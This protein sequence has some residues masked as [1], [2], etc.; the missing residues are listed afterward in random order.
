MIWII[1]ALTIPVVVWSAQVSD[2][3]GYSAPSFAGSAYIP[4]LFGAIVLV[5]GGRVFLNG[6]RVKLASRQPGM[7]TLIS[8]AIAVAFVASAA[9][10]L[11]LFSVDVWWELTTLITVMS[12]GHWPEMRAIRQARGQLSALAELLL[13][14]GAL[15]M[16]LSD[17]HRSGQRPA[18]AAAEAG[19]TVHCSA[20][21]GLT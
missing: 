11:G 8:L 13:S 12:L 15:A 2:W 20:G 16:S 18:P 5:Y 19:G 17:G 21:G 10:T 14:V 3:L 7:M 6:A 9:A 4:A 1:L